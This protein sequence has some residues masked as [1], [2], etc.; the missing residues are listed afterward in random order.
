MARNPP[1]TGFAI[2]MHIMDDERNVIAAAE[3]AHA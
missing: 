3:R 2:Y 1:Q